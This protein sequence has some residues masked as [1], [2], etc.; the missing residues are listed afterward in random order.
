MVP[1]ENKC[2][3]LTCSV[4]RK[5]QINVESP[6]DPLLFLLLLS[7]MAQLKLS[8]VTA[9]RQCETCHKKLIRQE[10][11]DTHRGPE[12]LHDRIMANRRNAYGKDKKRGSI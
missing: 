7:I 11:T 8:P 4:P 10:E 5:D 9:Y 1:R 2:D 12:T 6:E 3:L